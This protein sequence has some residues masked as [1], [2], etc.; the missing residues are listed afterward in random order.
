VYQLTI[1]YKRK[2]ALIITIITYYH[3]SHY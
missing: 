2:L 1:K 3:N